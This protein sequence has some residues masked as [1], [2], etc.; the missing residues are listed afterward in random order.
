[1]PGGLIQLISTGRQDVYLTNNPQ[2]TFFK[3][4]YRRHTPFAINTIENFFTTKPN[5]GGANST[6]I[7]PKSGDIVFGMTLKV[8]LPKLVGSTNNNIAW[9]RKIGY[10]IIDSISIEIGGTKIDTLYGTW[11]NIWNE[12]TYNKNHVK[13]FNKLIGDTPE[14]TELSTLIPSYTVYIPLNFWFC[15]HVGLGIPIIALN[16]HNI[17]ISLKLNKS[18]NLIVYDG[19]RPIIPS[20]IDSSLLIDYIYLDKDERNLFSKIGHE[21]LIEQ[22]QYNKNFLIRNDTFNANIA[23]NHPIKELYWTIKNNDFFSNKKF[24]CY[25][26]SDD[27]SDAINYASNNIVYGM[28]N[29]DINGIPIWGNHYENSTIW[30]TSGTQIIQNT[31]LY[32]TNNNFYNCIVNISFD[33]SITPEMLTNGFSILRNTSPMSY[34]IS[35]IY[36]TVT[37]SGIIIDNVIHNINIKDIS[38]PIKEWIIDN[39]TQYSK[40]FDIVVNQAFNYGLYLDNTINSVS[41][42]VLTLNG[43][44]R[45]MEMDGEYFNYLQPL[46][47]HNNTPSDGINI[48]SFSIN[49][50]K[51]Q[52]SG[53]C[54]MSRITNSILKINVKDDH[55]M[56]YSLITNSNTYFSIFGLNYN[57]FK[58]IEGYG[59]LAYKK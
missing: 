33:N 11:L 48:Y 20:I 53:T 52:P 8:T 34:K 47:Y 51:H 31:N 3:A 30:N 29:L 43:Q 54:N 38:I 26:N 15:K 59:G 6:M 23:F 39:R 28:C 1:M 32:N 5:F 37:S 41:S 12:L 13:G 50:E 10:A 44:E 14:L 2:I 35:E 56:N 27:W 45:F 57:V 40:T 17:V 36:L 46:R 4:V 24:L 9:V 18:D 55:D 58:V 21:Y 25:S 22:I 19:N 42:A 7:I 16:K 49:P